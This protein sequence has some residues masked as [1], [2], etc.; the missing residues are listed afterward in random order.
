V[1]VL[2]PTGDTHP[3]HDS[4]CKFRRE[5]GQ[6]VKEAF[7]EVLA[8]AKQMGLMKIGTVSVDGIHIKANASKHRSVRYD[9]AAELEQQLR[10]DIEELLRRAEQ[11]EL[12]GRSIPEAVVMRG[13]AWLCGSLGP[14]RALANRVKHG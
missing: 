9:R 11:T 4:I 8:L 5:N 1:A 7:V 6:G 2:Y 10:K 14:A 12:I 3:D 13:A